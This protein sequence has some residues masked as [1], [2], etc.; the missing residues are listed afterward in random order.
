MEPGTAM[1]LW[2]LNRA[3]I[4][5]DPKISNSA[6]TVQPIT[7]TKSSS[8]LSW[9]WKQQGSYPKSF[10]RC[11]SMCGAW[12]FQHLFPSPPI[13]ISQLCNQSL[14][15]FVSLILKTPNCLKNILS[16][17]TVWSLLYRTAQTLRGRSKGLGLTA[18]VHSEQRVLSCWSNPWATSCC[19]HSWHHSL[20]QRVNVGVCMWHKRQKPVI[21]SLSSH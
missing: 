1:T 3:E 4:I 10:Q 17:L 14:S 5:S 12:S 19:G 2:S 18:E 11:G 8:S 20:F 9:G 6:A 16:R 21:K 13:L 7:F 15:V